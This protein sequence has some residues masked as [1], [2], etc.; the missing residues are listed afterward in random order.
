MNVDCL[1]C[2]GDGLYKGPRTKDE[3]CPAC[4]GTGVVQMS[5]PKT[6]GNVT[7]LRMET[8]T[9]MVTIR[10]SE[11]GTEV[12]MSVSAKPARET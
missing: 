2:G 9:L 6:A 1:S 3:P 12:Q 7:V 8:S 4:D 11:D 10:M 5:A